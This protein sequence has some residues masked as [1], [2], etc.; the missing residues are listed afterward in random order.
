MIAPETPANIDHD[1][2]RMTFDEM[3]RVVD[4]PADRVAVALLAECGFIA[5]RRH[6]GTWPLNEAV[7]K[8]LKHDY[9]AL[10]S[11]VYDRFG[12]PNVS[13]SELS[14]DS[15]FRLQEALDDIAV[16]QLDASV[17]AAYLLGIAIARRL[18]APVL[19][20]QE[21]ERGGAAAETCEANTRT[22]PSLSSTPLSMLGQKTY[23]TTEEAASYLCAPSV[24]AFRQF[25]DRARL[26]KCRAG[27]KVLFFRKD[28]DAAVQPDHVRARRAKDRA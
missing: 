21:H 24:K 27:R 1:G 20:R 12:G 5:A 11:E 15:R 4:G 14:A 28:L 19:L 26:P 6:D 18:T 23:L 9:A 16:R 17:E 25:A 2:D 13:E 10:V 7:K 22:L 3:T 8:L